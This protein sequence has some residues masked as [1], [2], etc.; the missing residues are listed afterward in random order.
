[1]TVALETSSPGDQAN[2]AVEE[3]LEKI[4]GYNPEADVEA[5]R[6]AYDYAAAAHTRQVRDSGPPYIDQPPPAP[7]TL[8][9]PGR[10]P[11]TDFD[12]PPPHALE[13]PRLAR[14]RAR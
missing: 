4:R 12:S 10:A 7:K 1:M 13:D 11:G 6:R 8:A 14:G 3:L 9:R 5:V 2:P